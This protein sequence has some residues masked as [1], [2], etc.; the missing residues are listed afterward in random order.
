MARYEQLT[1]HPD[2]LKAKSLVEAARTLIKGRHAD[3]H[4]W[5]VAENAI[6]GPRRAAQDVGAGSIAR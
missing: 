5:A 3:E 6:L 1:K 4:V 2:E